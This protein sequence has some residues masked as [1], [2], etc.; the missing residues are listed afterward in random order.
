MA[1]STLAFQFP[2]VSPPGQPLE[3]N[4]NQE[5]GKL[6]ESVHLSDCVPVTKA[7]NCS[8]FGNCTQSEYLPD[9]LFDYAIGRQQVNFLWDKAAAYSSCVLNSF[10]LCV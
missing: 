1:I 9:V 8:P 6:I 5:T 7:T 3:T 4:K 2:R 10:C